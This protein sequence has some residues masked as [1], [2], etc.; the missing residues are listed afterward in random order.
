[1]K[2]KKLDLIVHSVLVLSPII[3]LA[4]YLRGF[5]EFKWL[6]LIYAVNIVM[7]IP[8][9]FWDWYKKQFVG[10]WVFSL[11]FFYSLPWIVLGIDMTDESYNLSVAWFYPEI[12]TLVGLKAPVSF[13]ITHVWLK[14][15]GSPFFLWER[16]VVNIILSLILYFSYKTLKSFD[17]KLLTN[18]FAPVI[19]FFAF[20]VLSYNWYRFLV[21][22]DKIPMLLSVVFVYLWFVGKQKQSQTM[23]FLSGL[24]L[25]LAMF[26]RITIFF[27]LPLVPFFSILR[28]KRPQKT[29]IFAITGIVIGLIIISILPVHPVDYIAGNIKLL[30]ETGNAS[31]CIT[32]DQSHKPIKLLSLYFND[33]MNIVPF[34]ASFLV[35]FGLCQYLVSKIK[36]PKPSNLYVTV[37]LTVIYIVIFKFYHFP[38]KYSSW[39]YSTAGIYAAL[40]VMTFILKPKFFVEKWDFIFALLMVG[41]IAFAGSNAGFR[42]IHF[43][44][45][46]AFIVPIIIGLVY[47]KINKPIIYTSLIF[48]ILIGLSLN[49]YYVYRD[50]PVMKVNDYF[51]T[52]ITK[53][54]WTSHK[55][56]QEI[57]AFNE[58]I[59][60]YLKDGNFVPAHKTYFFALSTNHKPANI[61]WSVSPQGLDNAIETG[62]IKYIVFSNRSMRIP[63]WDRQDTLAL[64]W[65]YERVKKV[66]DLLDQKAEKI[67]SSPENIFVLYRAIKKE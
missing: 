45:A 20:G 65:D 56:I 64:K 13:L 52:G 30:R 26:S 47:D 9:F 49:F 4:L 17:N 18:W 29:L 61:C 22:Y 50:Y 40:L 54:L 42:K 10:Y 12:E 39:F 57:Q 21:P 58:Q 46:I 43:N 16:I 63:T 14:L 28:D 8:L 23:I 51:K 48:I 1:M 24:F 33:L 32:L 25:V 15:I 62:Q 27:L 60:P 6:A 11:T 31:L 35:L 67:V 2:N 38:E 3:N 41:I 36:L 19:I 7:L 5:Y 37:I 55:K 53:G 66:K 59:T 44:F 34:F